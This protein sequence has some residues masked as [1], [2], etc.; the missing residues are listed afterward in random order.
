MIIMIC[1][2]FCTSFTGAGCSTESPGCPIWEQLL[3]GCPPVH[4]RGE[5]LHSAITSQ[6]RR[7]CRLSQSLCLQTDWILEP[8]KLRKIK[9]AMEVDCTI[10]YILQRKEQQSWHKLL[11]HL[12][13]VTVVNHRAFTMFLW[14]YI[15]AGESHNLSVAHAFFPC[16][17]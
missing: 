13:V 4:R 1:I 3:H 10:Q 8:K 9:K 15:S 14:P 17:L 7:Y 5:E 11:N 6:L 2:F 12:L 16:F